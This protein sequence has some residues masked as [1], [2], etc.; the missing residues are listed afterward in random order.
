[1]SETQEDKV[2]MFSFIYELHIWIFRYVFKWEYSPTESRRVVKGDG[3]D[4][5]W[6]EIEHRQSEGEK[7]RLEQ[8][9][10]SEM[11]WKGKVEEIN[12]KDLWKCIWKSTTAEDSNGIYLYR[13]H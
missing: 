8:E 2:Y 12:T 6:E 3:R 13:W 10:L 1:M 11:G 9:G 7:W 5:K 4:S